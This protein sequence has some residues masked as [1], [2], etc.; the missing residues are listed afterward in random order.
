VNEFVAER[1]GERRLVHYWYR[2]WRRT[3]IVGGLDQNLDR[4]AGRLLQGRADGAL[5]RISASLDGV[6]E[7]ELRSRLLAF[8]AA[9]EPLLATHWPREGPSEG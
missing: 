1:D 7:V 3:G 2:S 9:L 4:L 6:D 8:G 5:V